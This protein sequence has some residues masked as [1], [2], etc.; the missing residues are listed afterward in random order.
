[1]KPF[2]LSCTVNGNGFLDILVLFGYI[3]AWE[4]ENNK[5]KRSKSIGIATKH[6]DYLV[7]PEKEYMLIQID[8]DRPIFFYSYVEQ[9]LTSYVLYTLSISTAWLKQI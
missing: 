2:Y 6:N 4:N 3:V 1:M 7:V 8:P 5:R 9:C